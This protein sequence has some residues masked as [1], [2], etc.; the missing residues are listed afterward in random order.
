MTETSAM[1]IRRSIAAILPAVAIM[2]MMTACAP[3][4]DDASAYTALPKSGWCYGDTLRF[5]PRMDDSIASGRLT[6]AVRHDGSYPY[7]DLYLEVSYPRNPSDTADRSVARDTVGM[8]LADMSGR[9]LG[10]GFGASYQCFATL[11]HRVALRDSGEVSVR[12]VMRVDTLR[13]IV[14]AGI[15]FTADDVS[16]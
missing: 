13:G 12:H 3:N 1:T 8:A 4:P 11:G 14:Q 15:I 16:D 5:R 2:A 9:W 10:Q 6:V 7:A